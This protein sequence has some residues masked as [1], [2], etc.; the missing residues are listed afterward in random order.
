M[1]LPPDYSKLNES[2][3][4]DTDDEQAPA[5]ARARMYLFIFIFSV[6]WSGFALGASFSNGIKDAVVAG[7]NMTVGVV[8]VIIFLVYFMSGAPRRETALRSISKKAICE[9][10]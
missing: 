1:T 10:P 5:I 4:A 6:L 8:N 3:A 9:F 7:V 2:V